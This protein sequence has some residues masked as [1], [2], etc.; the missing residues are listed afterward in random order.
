M[1]AETAVELFERGLE[2]HPQAPGALMEYGRA[3][4]MLHGDARM[5]EATQLYEKAAAL[6]PADAKERLDVELARAGLTD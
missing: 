1:R 3:L 2:L 5:G 4:L 6:K